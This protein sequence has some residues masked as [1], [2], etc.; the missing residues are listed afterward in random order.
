MFRGHPMDVVK[1]SARRTVAPSK[2]LNFFFDI[3]FFNSYRKLEVNGD[4]PK[5]CVLFYTLA[6]D[7]V[8][9]HCDGSCPKLC[10]A[11]SHKLPRHGLQKLEDFSISA[12]YCEFCGGL[13]QV[14]SPRYFTNC[15]EKFKEN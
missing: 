14:I 3:F 5:G 2:D 13:P 11:H 6:N 1:P 4:E 7:D 15:I 9:P 12:V 10:T 8:V